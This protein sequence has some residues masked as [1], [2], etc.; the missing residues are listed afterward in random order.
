[1]GCGLDWSAVKW[2]LDGSVLGML[3]VRLYFNV[4]LNSGT[5]EGAGSGPL[6]CCVGVLFE[7]RRFS[8]PFTLLCRALAQQS[9]FKKGTGNCCL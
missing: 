4:D 8:T 1:M 5:K 3:F 2:N 7:L 9:L 6:P